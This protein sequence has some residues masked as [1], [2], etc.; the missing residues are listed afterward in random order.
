MAF[1]AAVKHLVLVGN[2]VLDGKGAAA[3][4]PPTRAQKATANT[5]M[6]TER[7]RRI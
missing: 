5:A 3:V 1:K 6:E 2:L 4:E 7:Y